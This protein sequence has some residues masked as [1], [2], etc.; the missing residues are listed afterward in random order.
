MKVRD[1]RYDRSAGRMSPA[2]VAAL[3]PARLAAGGPLGRTVA[4][5]PGETR[6]YR[7][8][9]GWPRPAA[10]SEY[11][12]QIGCRRP[13]GMAICW[14]GRGAGASVPCGV[15]QSGGRGENY[16]QTGTEAAAAGTGGA[17]RRCR[18]A[19]GSWN[20]VAV[21]RR[22]E[23]RQPADKPVQLPLDFLQRR[24]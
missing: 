13:C 20:L 3:N 12:G 17:D 18:T 4:K 10:L 15:S 8:S 24:L 1:H 19:A 11:P 5:N 21:E 7:P 16:I 23:L 9:W 6:D 2:T 22:H 14:P